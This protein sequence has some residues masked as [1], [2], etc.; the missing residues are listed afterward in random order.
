MIFRR[1]EQ[2]KITCGRVS[3]ETLFND[4]LDDTI[5]TPKELE[6]CIKILT[7]SIEEAAHD[8]L[9]NAGYEDDGYDHCQIEVYFD[10][11]VKRIEE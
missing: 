10:E 7:Q 2:D 3:A 9:E 5:K 1:N 11:D 8:W 6:W 4:I